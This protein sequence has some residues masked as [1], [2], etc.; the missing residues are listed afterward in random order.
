MKKNPL[1]TE[2][3][4]QKIQDAFWDIHSEKCI[5]KITVREITERAG[6]NRST[7]YAYYKDVYDLLEQAEEEII[8]ALMSEHRWH[9]DDIF[10]TDSYKSDLKNIG[11]FLQNHQKQLSILIGEKGDPRFS[12]RLWNTAWRDL[13]QN[14]ARVADNPDD[15]K[16]D[17]IVENIIN[18][19]AGILMLW[20]RNGCV[21]PFE[22][23]ADL[24]YRLMSG[25]V[26]PFLSN[27]GSPYDRIAD[28]ILQRIKEK[29]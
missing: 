13:R 25:G 9:T 18:C 21:T 12:S 6:L 20:F 17:Y 1:Q 28:Y 10:N 5:E 22:E 16:L 27:K 19:H 26:L 23:I 29:L 14:I 8:T 11:E 15:P 2:L 4:K 3:T 24:T 7:F